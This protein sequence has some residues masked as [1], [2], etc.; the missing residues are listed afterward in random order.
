MS[1]NMR[2]FV[3]LYR[4]YRRGGYRIFPAVKRASRAWNHGF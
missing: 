3:H 4:Y 1:V 2:T